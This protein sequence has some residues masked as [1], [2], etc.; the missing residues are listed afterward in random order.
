MTKKLIWLMISGLIVTSLLVASCAAPVEE[1]VVEE[2]E[3]EFV[4]EIEEVEEVEEVALEASKTPIYGG[5][6]TF[7]T[8]MYGGFGGPP[9]GTPGRSGAT[10]PVMEVMGWGDWAK[11]PQGT[12]ECGYNDPTLDVVNCGRGTLIESWE[13][14]GPLT[15]VGHIRPGVKFNAALPA[16]RAIVGDREFVA[17]DLFH[18]WDTALNTPGVRVSMAEYLESINVIDRYT[19]E[20]VLTK[21]FYAAIANLF[22]MPTAFPREIVDE[23]GDWSDWHN[24]CGTGPFILTDLVEGA[25][26]TFER[27]TE[28]WDYDELRPEYQLP[29]VDR[30]KQLVIVDRMTEIAGLRTGKLD[31]LINITPDEANALEQTNPELLRRQVLAPDSRP[32]FNIRLDEPPFD[33]VRVRQAMV[34]ALDFQ[35]IVDTYWRGDGVAFCEPA[36]PILFPQWFVP[37]EEL[38]EDIQKIRT[39]DPVAARQLLD[40]AIGP[41][42]ELEFEINVIAMM[43]D[44][45]LVFQAYWEEI[46]AHGTIN[47]LEGG[48][49]RDMQKAGTFHGMIAQNAVKRPPYRHAMEPQDFYPGENYEMDPI[50]EALQ[51]EMIG[52]IDPDEQW[53]LYEQARNFQLRYVPHIR[54]PHPFVNWYWQPWLGG[55][56]GETFIGHYGPLYARLWIDQTVKKAMGH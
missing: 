30:L 48:T 53:D 20:Y 15:F 3:E 38:P 42:A 50:W 23:F 54:F 41:G 45:A 10:N 40:E 21:P 6:F 14:T 12:E 18:R 25:S 1:E 47:T 37:L 33:D 16:T 2:E 52:T 46:G 19:I 11:G 22:Y 17:E 26:L 44:P 28:Y 29:Y 8:D 31:Y 9:L 55:Y 39:Y 4:S 5:T 51:D 56:E 7:S 24:M 34:M 13:Q 35:E 27:N 43:V 49:L 32:M 36:D